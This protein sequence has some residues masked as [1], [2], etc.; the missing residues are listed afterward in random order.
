VVK[1][2][3][4]VCS[5]F[6][7]LALVAGSACSRRPASSSSA[8]QAGPASAATPPGPNAEQ[9]LESVTG[10]VVET[11]DAASYTYMRLK[12]PKG[13]VWAATGKTT[14]KVGD[15]VVVP[16]ETE[17]RNFHSPSVNR[18]FPVI[19]FVSQITHDGEPAAPPMALG[20]GMNGMPVQAPLNV[21][22]MA[23]P[24]GGSSI[25]EVWAKRTLLVGR[26][27]TVNGK[28]VKF[29][30]GILGRNWLHVQDGSGN[31]ADGTND[32]TVTTDAVAKVGD[33]VTVTG[34]VVI[35]KDLGAGYVYKV[36]LE[37]GRIK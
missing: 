8:P 12:T 1:T 32:L 18:D 11:M 9:A 29:N 5:V 16:L 24:A 37:N 21:E 36:L 34:T 19:Y 2:W 33:V 3:P 4:V 26:T 20:H 17:M 25:A 7:A 27:V 31:A 13:E 10:E 35:D 22:P 14:V 6:V 28:V 15:K 23:P 30:G